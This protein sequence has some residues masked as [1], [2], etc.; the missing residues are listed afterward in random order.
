MRKLLPVTPGS[1]TPYFGRLL[2]DPALVR[3]AGISTPTPDTPSVNL[4]ARWCSKPLNR[5]YQFV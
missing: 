1:E 3:T 4:L 5:L 2:L